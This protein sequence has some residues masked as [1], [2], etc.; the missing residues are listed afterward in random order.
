MG[1]VLS[2]FS[3]ILSF[4]V[5]SSLGI[6]V[7]LG[8]FVGALPGLTACMAVALLIP[9]T[10]W[11]PPSAGLAMLIGVYN[12]AIF[13]G[14]IS[15]VLINTPGTPASIA[16]TFDGY[17]LVKKGFVALAVWINT[18]YSVLGGIFGA[19]MLV[20]AAFPIAKFALKFGPAEYSALALFGLSMM[21]SVSGK[22]VVKGL[23]A[24]FLGLAI[25]TIGLD[26]TYAVSR[27]SFG[28]PYLLAHISFL[29][30]MIGLFGI[31]EILDQVITPLM[32]GDIT[33]ING[34]KQKGFLNLKEIWQTKIAVLY[35]CIVSVF[36][37][38]IPGTGG[39]IAGIVSW[40]HCRRF[41]KQGKEYGKGSV[42]ALAVTCASNNASLGGAMTTM[43]SLG[44]PGDAPTAILIGALMM[45]GYIP[46]PMLFRD[47]MDMVAV[48]VA[49]MFVAYLFIAIVGF[50]GTK[51]FPKLLKLPR[52]WI[53]LA[54][55]CF[56]LVGA[57]ALNNSALDIMVCLIAGIVGFIFRRTGFP[58]GPVIIALILGPIAEENI[59]RALL[60]AR[61]DA[62]VFLTRPISLILIIASLLSLFLVP[63][64]S[65]IMEGKEKQ[66]IL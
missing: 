22:S 58:L 66:K 6:G 49:L 31:G 60:L 12:S 37:G 20:I 61:G 18:F 35:A 17:K 7:L 16:S 45:Y 29:P 24:G 5:L 56:S 15:A 30:I 52:P 14:G 4:Q 39:D 44:I 62:M 36:I 57:Y 3:S 21:I 10:F 33:E 9:I 64:L 48:I 2:G 34:K 41:S 11:L 46:G 50:L 32:K 25:T 28:S 23:I 40:D 13:A 55:F 8:V 19:I 51:V 54:V 42:E 1:T 27:F 65:K 47:H 26:P 38:A 63:I 53:N 43:L 59:I